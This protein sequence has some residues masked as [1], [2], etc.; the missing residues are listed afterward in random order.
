[1]RRMFVNPPLTLLHPEIHDWPGRGAR[2]S[3]WLVSDASGR[4]SILALASVRKLYFIAAT[5]KVRGKSF[6]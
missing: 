4:L 1:M 5:G 2:T 6:P 3:I